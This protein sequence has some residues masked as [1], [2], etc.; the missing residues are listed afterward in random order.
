MNNC[1]INSLEEFMGQQYIFAEIDFF[2][3]HSSYEYK[4]IPSIGRLFQDG[5][6][7]LMKHYEKEIFNDFKRKFSLILLSHLEIIV[8]LKVLIYTHKMSGL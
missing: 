5:K 7:E 3:G 4:L 1:I 8:L 2:R 6:E